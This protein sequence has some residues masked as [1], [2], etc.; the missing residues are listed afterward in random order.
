MGGLVK[1]SGGSRGFLLV[2][3]TPFQNSKF[4]L[5]LSIALETGSDSE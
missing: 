1:D 5:L 4:I 3:T 2:R